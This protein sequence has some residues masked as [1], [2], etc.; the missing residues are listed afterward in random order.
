M[1]RRRGRG[2]AAAPARIHRA[3]RLTPPSHKS[4]TL[5][6]LFTL[7]GGLSLVAGQQA[8]WAGAE[9]LGGDWRDGWDECGWAPAGLRVAE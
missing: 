6:R 5:F 3:A 1:G 4:A 8:R 2:H 7:L 9:A